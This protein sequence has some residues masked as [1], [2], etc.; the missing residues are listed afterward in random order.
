MK[1]ETKYYIMGT[2]IAF[3]LSAATISNSVNIYG[4]QDQESE[5]NPK[6]NATPPLSLNFTDDEVKTPERPLNNISV[7]EGMEKSQSGNVIPGDQ[8]MKF[9]GQQINQTKQ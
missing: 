2:F 5:P 9:E 7:L 8:E 4:Q 1:T 3:A 6:L